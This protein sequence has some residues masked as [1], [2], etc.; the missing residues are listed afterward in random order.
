MHPDFMPNT[1]Q[2][3]VWFIQDLLRKKEEYDFG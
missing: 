1:P 2:D 3:F